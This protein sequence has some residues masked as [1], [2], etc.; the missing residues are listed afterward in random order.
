MPVHTRCVRAQDKRARK[1]IKNADCRSVTYY[2]HPIFTRRAHTIVSDGRNTVHGRHS[3]QP[4]RVGAAY[5]AVA[6][7]GRVLGERR[8]SAALD[9]S[10]ARQRAE[11]KMSLLTQ[12]AVPGRP[13]TSVTRMPRAKFALLASSGSGSTWVNHMLSS[14]PC[15]ASAGEYLLKNASEQHLFRTPGGVSAVLDRI[16][17]QVDEQLRQHRRESREA[18]ACT[19]LVAGVK[20]KAFARDM[21]GGKGG[22]M[23]SVS[24]LLAQK[25]WRVVLLQ[26]QN[27]LARYLGQVSRKKTGVMHCPAGCDPSDLNVSTVLNCNRTLTKISGWEMLR[28]EADEEFGK[29]RGS[30]RFLSL[31]YEELL[32]SPRSWASIMQMLGFPPGDA[33]RLYTAGQKRVQQTQ[34]EMVQNWDN[35][36]VCVQTHWPRFRPLLRPNERPHSGPLPRDDPVM[37]GTS[38]APTI[39]P[40]NSVVV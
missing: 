3:Q 13:A 39:K 12:R 4:R 32:R 27:H 26:R 28:G 19:R 6:N 8:V 10:R 2:I 30:G 1:R 25:G 16:V 17:E 15:I 9:A 5:L 31:N 22:N 20:L 11:Q 14:H 24:R 40:Y 34:R 18:R 21:L 38:T 23:R 33:C 37:C 7:P 29:W 35:F 36:S